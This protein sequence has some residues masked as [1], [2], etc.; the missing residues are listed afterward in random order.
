MDNTLKRNTTPVRMRNYGRIIQDM[1]A[2]AAK[3]QDAE[4]QNQMVVY[5]AQCMRRKN[6]VWNK[7]Q[8]S[9]LARLRE[10][11]RILSNGVLTC[12]F[13]EFETMMQQV[14]QHPLAA[15]DNKPVSNN[16]KKKRK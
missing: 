5:I 16:A 9:G 15:S 12:E 6:A 13:P 7:E 8:E 11:I 14:L 4:R 3:E 10:D 2:I 1:V